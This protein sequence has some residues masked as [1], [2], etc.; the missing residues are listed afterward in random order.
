[1]RQQNREKVIDVT[2]DYAKI[3]YERGQAKVNLE[4]YKDAIANF[5]A[6]IRLKPDYAYAYFNRGIAK[7]MLKQASEAKQDLQT[8]LKLAEQAED[9]QL[10]KLTEDFLP[11]IVDSEFGNYYQSGLTKF[12]LQEYSNAIVNFDT[13]IRLKPDQADAYYYRGLAKL[14]LGQVSKAKQDLQTALKLAEQ[15][16]DTQFTAKIEAKFH[17]LTTS[18]PNGAKSQPDKILRTGDKLPPFTFNDVTDSSIGMI[19]VRRD[20]TYG[21]GFFAGIHWVGGIL[22]VQGTKY[23]PRCNSNFR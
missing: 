4:Q 11:L 2:P 16:G 23:G 9:A 18:L 8:A 22:T 21:S 20:A 5:D 3:H 7:W 13:V 12:I 10:K 17:S 19:I 14:E 15:A 1:M 6:A